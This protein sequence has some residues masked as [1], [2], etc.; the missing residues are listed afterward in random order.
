MNRLGTLEDQAAASA[1]LPLP[2]APA[3]IPPTLVTPSDPV[4][5]NIRITYHDGD[6]QYRVRASLD[7]ESW[8]LA[9]RF[10]DIEDVAAHCWLVVCE[11]SGL[12]VDLPAFDLP[13]KPTPTPR[14]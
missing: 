3:P 4:E 2:A 9:A 10:D 12:S 5:T 7:G 13:E 14:I 8:Q 6:G 11:R 1:G